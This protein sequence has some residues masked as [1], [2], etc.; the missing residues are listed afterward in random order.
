MTIAASSSFTANVFCIITSWYILFNACGNLSP[1]DCIALHKQRCKERRLLTSW[2]PGPLAPPLK[3]A[4]VSPTFFPFTFS[5]PVLSPPIFFTSLLSP[6]PLEVG[7]L[8]APPVTPPIYLLCH[9]TNANKT[10]EWTECFQIGRTHI[11]GL[12][13][14]R[15]LSVDSA[16]ESTVDAGVCCVP[17][18]HH[19]GNL[20]QGIGVCPRK[21]E[22]ERHSP[23]IWPLGKT[24][25]H[26]NS[27]MH[28][29]I[30]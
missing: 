18:V 21:T 20:S 8:R 14:T 15:T 1:Q 22:G 29:K 27:F 23:T 24:S 9:I 13:K 25:M 16:I 4:L 3:S 5:F 6:L 2:G 28:F 17:T 26:A 19:Q 11:R 12:V 10:W 7:P 30:S